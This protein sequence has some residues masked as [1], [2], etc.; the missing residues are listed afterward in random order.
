MDSCL[1]YGLKVYGVIIIGTVL[2]PMLL[3]VIARCVRGR[4]DN[5]WRAIHVPGTLTEQDRKRIKRE[6]ADHY[7]GTKHAWKVW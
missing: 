1:I 3:L 5:V 7:R 4:P 6:W 2:I